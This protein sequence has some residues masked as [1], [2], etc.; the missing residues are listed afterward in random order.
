MD[1]VHEI[2][3]GH[4]SLSGTILCVTDRIRFQISIAYHIQETGVTENKYSPKFSAE[5]K[6]SVLP[7]YLFPGKYVLPL[8]KKY[9]PGKE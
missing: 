6:Y 9:S 2:T 5:N 7:Q 3:A 4:R 8:G 1:T